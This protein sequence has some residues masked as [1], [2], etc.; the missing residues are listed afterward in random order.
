M[1]PPPRMGLKTRPLPVLHLH[2]AAA[3]PQVEFSNQKSTAEGQE[4]ATGPS[5]LPEPQQQS[6]GSPRSRQP[7]LTG[8]LGRGV[9]RCIPEP[10]QQSMG[11]PRSRQPVLTGPLGRADAGASLRWTLL[12]FPPLQPI[13]SGPSY[14]IFFSLH[15]PSAVSWV[16]CAAEKYTDAC[17][18]LSFMDK[19]ADVQVCLRPSSMTGA[20]RTRA[21]CLLP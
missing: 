16:I 3:P 17:S 7:V 21:P 15:S 5:G 14:P 19:S 10:Q 13:P 8:P 20:E 4:V 11:S 9:C 2:P 12:C 1:P 6:M 18:Y